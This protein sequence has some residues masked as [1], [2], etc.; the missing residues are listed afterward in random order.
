MAL[1]LSAEG[2]AALNEAFAITT[3]LEG[4]AVGTLSVNAITARRSL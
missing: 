1:T 4:D 3:L 2:A